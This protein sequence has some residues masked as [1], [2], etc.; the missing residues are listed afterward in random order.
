MPWG[1]ALAYLAFSYSQNA[2]GLPQATAFMLA[3]LVATL[4]VG[5]AAAAA[6]HAL[7][8]DVGIT[9]G[10]PISVHGGHGCGQPMVEIHSAWVCERCDRVS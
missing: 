8:E 1:T 3:I 2:P 10:R 9:H 6:L 4:T 5:I 7:P